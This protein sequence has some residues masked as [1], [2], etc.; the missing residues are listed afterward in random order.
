M[1]ISMNILIEKILN[2]LIAD[3]VIERKDIPAYRF[4]IEAM[5]LKILHYTTYFVLAVSLGKVTEFII[6]FA[7]F[8]VLRRNTGGYHAKTRLGCYFLSC[9]VVIGSLLATEILYFK[10]ISVVII[11]IEMVVLLLISPVEN[12][13]RPM[14]EEEV[15]SFKY[16]LKWVA[17]L[18][19]VCCSILLRLEKWY[20]LQLCMIGISVALIL[21]VVGTIQHKCGEKI[22]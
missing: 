3:N 12:K 5:M 4:G 10:S 6:I 21:V 9:A 17:V 11:I 8:V 20:I 7:A 2:K 14:D 19:T 15:V 22:R 18:V 1:L 16:Q 13:N